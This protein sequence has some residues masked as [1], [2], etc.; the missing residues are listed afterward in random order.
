MNKTKIALKPYLDTI[1][2]YCDT[3]SHQALT[4]VII[5]LAKDVSTSGRVTFLRKFESP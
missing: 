5:G 4:K 2:G 3:L 1:N